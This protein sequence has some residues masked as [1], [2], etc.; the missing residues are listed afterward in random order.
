MLQKIIRFFIT[1]RKEL[2]QRAFD[3]LQSDGILKAVKYVY[4]GEAAGKK[5]ASVAL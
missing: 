4:P 5:A 2:K 1:F 3:T